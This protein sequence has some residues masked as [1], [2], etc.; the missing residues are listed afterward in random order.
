MNDR[1]PETVAELG[2]EEEE[3]EP[4]VPED[5]PC[6]EAELEYAFDEF[7]E[8]VDADEVIRP[9]HAPWGRSRRSRSGSGPAA[10]R[11]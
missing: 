4:L 7:G 10:S 1:P 5:T 6:G 9:G 3:L 2:S 11:R 8:P